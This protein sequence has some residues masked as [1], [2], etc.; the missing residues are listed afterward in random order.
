MPAK[1]KY[2]AQPPIEILRQWMDH[3]GWYD[4]NDKDQ[5]FMEL[6][7]VQFLGAMGPPGGGRTRISERYVR[8]FNVLGFVPFSNE[9]L[10]K[11]FGTILSWAAGSFSSAVKQVVP[12]VVQATI[13][14]YN[15]ISRDM[16]PTP[17]KSHYTFNLRDLSKVFQ[18][19]NAG[20][21]KK[22]TEGNQYVR[23]WAHECM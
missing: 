15:A 16:L 6:T 18:G 5:A 11:M 17:A 7:D 3:G 2:G 10:Q 21:D 22:I 1:E 12:A 23:L 19:M 13:D 14:V 8:H 20:S 4:R 9:S